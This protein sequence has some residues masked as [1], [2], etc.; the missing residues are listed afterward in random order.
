MGQ[1]TTG[2]AALARPEAAGVAGRTKDAALQRANGN[3]ESGRVGSFRV[4]AAIHAKGYKHRANSMPA[5]RLLFPSGGLLSQGKLIGTSPNVNRSNTVQLHQG[6]KR[7]LPT[8]ERRSACA[9]RRVNGRAMGAGFGWSTG[10][11]IGNSTFPR[12]RHMMGLREISG[13]LNAMFYPPVQQIPRSGHR[14]QGAN[15]R[16]RDPFRLLFA[17]GLLSLISSM[18]TTGAESQLWGAAG[19]S[20]QVPGRLPDFS[21]AGYR[22]GQ[23]PPTLPPGKSVKEF[24]AK[25]DGEADDTAAFK[26]ALAEV[27]GAIEVPPGRYRITEILYISRPGQVLR[28]AGPHE[29]VLVCP[30]PLNEIKPDWGATTGGRPTSNYSWSGGMVWIKGKREWT[31]LATISGNPRRGATTLE[32][33]AATP[34]A[35]GD[36]IVIQVRDDAQDSL[37]RHLYSDD[38]GETAELLGRT[39][40][41]LPCR[42][43]SV[44]GDTITIDRPLRFDVSPEW[45]PEISRFDFT[46]SE[47]G[48]EELGF[49]FPAKPYEGHFTELGHNAVAIEGA[50]HC[51][52]RNIRIANADSGLFVSGYFCTVT[53]VEFESARETDDRNHT[54]HHGIYLGGDDNLFTRFDYRTRFIH[55]ITVS[56][57]AGNVMSEG[58]GVDLSLDHHK[59]A[60]YENLFTALDAGAGTRLWFCGG[61]AA[62]G[63]H[64]AARGTFWNIRSARPL[65]YPPGS[66]APHSINVVG[67]PSTGPSVTD[68]DGKWFEVFPGETVEPLNLHQ[69]QVEFRTRQ[70]AALSP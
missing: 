27:D 50:A 42:V 30:V 6:I 58:R 8:V 16:S 52:I 47:S 11:G 35:E 54:G 19:E 53:G 28:G 26:R 45:K 15:P 7:V 57:C 70:A 5:R 31:T 21:L 18:T 61:G 13:T 46:V 69:A 24:G 65:A 10:R 32:V 38:P 2:R 67:L 41:R 1:R 12:S 60:P 66:F 22:R 17:V 44:E 4:A 56:K 23:T 43:I 51:W 9:L 34:L 59:R 20:W 39:S 25:G 55:D 33:K 3:N 37:A 14:I 49:E 36:D 64:C 29:S 48:V 68:A 63:K 62:L 40:A